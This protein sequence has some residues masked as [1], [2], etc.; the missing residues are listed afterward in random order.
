MRSNL[1][2]LITYFKAYK[3]FDPFDA[4]GFKKLVEKGILMK[5]Y[6]IEFVFKCGVKRMAHGWRKAKVRKS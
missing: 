3:S 5:D 1:K 6:E 2:A 4:V